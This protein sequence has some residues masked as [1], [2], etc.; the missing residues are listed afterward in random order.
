MAMYSELTTKNFNK[1]KQTLQ[2]REHKVCELDPYLFKHKILSQEEHE[3]EAIKVMERIKVQY[4]QQPLNGKLNEISPQEMIQEGRI[5]VNLVI[6]IYIL[7]QQEK[8]IFQK[9]D[10]SIQQLQH[11]D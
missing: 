9:E 6:E 1:I 3:N 4:N 5:F 11:S 2:E 7:F 10:K 8:K